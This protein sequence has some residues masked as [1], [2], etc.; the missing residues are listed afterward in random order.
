[1]LNRPCSSRHRLIEP[2][3][4]MTR[5]YAG[6]RRLGAGVLVFLTCTAALAEAAAERSAPQ[7]AATAATAPAVKVGCI[8]IAYIAANSRQGKL[9]L[10]ELET[11]TRT[12]QVELDERAKMLG[13]H[14][15]KLRKEATAMTEA[16]RL[17]LERTLRKAQLEFARFREDTQT[18]VQQFADRIEQSLRARLFPIVDEIS[19]EKGLTLVFTVD[20][21]GLVWFSPALDVSKDVVQRLD[22]AQ[23]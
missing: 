12:K 4:M 10:S 11:F 8:D 20:A 21:P 16:A 17:D 7:A 15:D 23:P 22:R 19:K 3:E 14:E 13:A 18:E 5:P 9:E 1:M 2:E 6:T